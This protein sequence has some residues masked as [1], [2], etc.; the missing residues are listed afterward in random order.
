VAFVSDARY[1][2]PA[3]VS[4]RV[5]ATEPPAYSPFLPFSGEYV[6]RRQKGQVELEVDGTLGDDDAWVVAR[7]R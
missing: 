5:Y 4:R 2:R 3:S 1:R 7:P 6:V